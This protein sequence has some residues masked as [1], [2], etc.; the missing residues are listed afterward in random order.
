MSQL[1]R[2]GRLVAR[3]RHDESPVYLLNG[4]FL[5]LAVIVILILA[6]ALTLWAVLR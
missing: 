3:G 2:L 5:A 4:V 6:A 1:P